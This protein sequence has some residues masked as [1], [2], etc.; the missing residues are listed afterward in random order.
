MSMYFMENEERFYPTY[1][2]GRTKQ[3]FK[4]QT[5]VNKIIQRYQKTGV[6]SHLE[7][8]GAVYGEFGDYDFHH[9]MQ[10]LA[11]GK[12]IFE[13][14]PSELRREFNQNPSEFFEFVNNPDNQERLDK[15]LPQ[16]AEPGNFDLDASSATPPGATLDP[17]VDTGAPTVAPEPPEAE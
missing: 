2:P 17:D 11:K 1:G 3:S 6:M 7:K 16:L 14:L 5:D 10:Q 15:L 9:H 13:Q 8:H 12:E 4:D